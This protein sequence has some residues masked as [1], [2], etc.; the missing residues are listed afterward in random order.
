MKNFKLNKRNAGVASAASKACAWILSIM[1]VVTGLAPSF[2]NNAKAGNGSATK[3]AKVEAK[4]KTPSKAEV[5][6]KDKTTSK[7]KAP[8]KPVASKKDVSSSSKKQKSSKDNDDK[9]GKKKKFKNKR[10]KTFKL[11]ESGNV[12]AEIVFE[13]LRIKVSFGHDDRNIDRKKWG[14]MV[15]ALGGSYNENNSERI[16]WSNA[17]GFDKLSLDYYGVYLPKDSSYF[18]YGFKKDIEKDSWSKKIVVDNVE[19]MSHMFEAS[20]VPSMNLSNWKLNS[21]LLGDSN[22]MQN[23]LTGCSNLEWLKTPVGLKTSISGANNNFKIVKL[24]KGSAAVVESENKNLNNDYEINSAGDKDA[25]YHIYRKDTH[26]GVTFDKNSGDSDSFRNHE[27]VKKGK[28]FNELSGE[29]PSEVPKKEGYIFTGW[30]YNRADKA[31]T[32]DRSKNI[33]DDITLYAVYK[34]IKEEIPLNDSGNV[35]V[36]LKIEV[37]GKITL[38]VKAKNLSGDM[39]ID[40]SK[41]DDMARK[42]GVYYANNSSGFMSWGES[43]I[44]NIHF[45][46]NGIDLPTDSSYLFCRLRGEIK[47]CEKVNTS[48][49]T[50]M[51]SMFQGIDSADPDVSRWNTSNVTNMASMFDG[52]KN[53]NPDVSNWD[54]SKVTNMQAMFQ[55]GSANPDVSKW[56]VSK[57]TNMQAMFRKTEIREVDLSKWKLNAKLLGNPDNADAMFLGCKNLSFLK[58]PVGLK[59][60][61][62]YLGRST[63]KIVKLKKGSVAVVEQEHKELNN[64]GYMINSS[65]DKDA[66]YYLYNRYYYFGVTFDKNDGDDESWMNYEIAS[67]GHSIKESKGVLPEEKPGKQGY[68]FKGWDKYAGAT[69]SGNFT[70]DTKVDSDITVYAIYEPKAPAK[71]KF[72]A[73]GGELGAIPAEINTF[74]GD[75]LGDKFPVEHPAKNG[76]E[77]VGWSKRAEDSNTGKIT[78]GAEFN[79]DTVIDAATVEVYAVWKAKHKLTVSFDGNGGELGSIPTSKDVY[80]G[81]TLGS[82]FPAYDPKNVANMDPKKPGHTFIGWG[83]DKTSTMPE[84]TKDTVFTKSEM[85]YAVWK[86]GASDTIAVKF[87][88]N[89]GSYKSGKMPSE[90][91]ERGTAL[92]ARFPTEIPEKPGKA[93]LG[94]A[95][96]ASATEPDITPETIFNEGADVY[97]V[98]KDAGSV[99]KVEFDMQGGKPEIAPIYAEAGKKLGDRFPKTTPRKKGYEFVGY[100]RSKA[101]ADTGEITYVNKVDKDTNIT[102]DTLAYAAFKE[103]KMVTIT[104]AANGGNGNMDAAQVDKG[105]NYKLPECKFTAP[106][107]KEFDK[108]SVA[109]GSAQAADQNP[110]DEIVASDNVTVTAKWKAKPIPKVNITF[111]NDGGTG[112][113]NAAEIEKGK[114]YTLPVC[115][116]VPPAGKEFDKWSVTVGS[117]PAVDKKPGESVTASDNVAVKAMWKTKTVPVMA[118]VTLHAEGVAGYPQ[119]I[120]VKRGE[121]LGDKLPAKIEKA[122]Y[123]F[124]GYSKENNGDINFFSDTAVKE[125]MNVYAVYKSNA[126]VVKKV[127]NIRLTAGSLRMQLGDLTDVFAI[128]APNDATDKRVKFTLDREDIIKI[129]SADDSAARVEAI[130]EGRV[131]VKAE[132][133]DG[134]GVT[135]EVTIEV[136]RKPVKKVQVKLNAEGVSGYPKTIETEEGTSLDANLPMDLKKDGYIFRGWSYE[137]NGEVNFTKHTQVSKNV[138]VHA[139]F[140]K[141]E[142]SALFIAEGATG[143]P[144]SVTVERGKK[145]GDKLPANPVRAGYDFEGW[146]TESSFGAL[147]LT[148][149]TVIDKDEIVYAVFKKQGAIVKQVSSITLGVTKSNIKAGDEADVIASIL[150][151]DADDKRLSWESSAPDKLKIEQTGDNFIRIKAEEEGT[152]TITAKAKDGSNVEANI[153]IKVLSKISAPISNKVKVMI[154]ADGVADYPKL[155]EI[156]KN[157]T[158][159]GKLPTDINKPGY[160]FKGFTKTMGNP[161]DFDDNEVIKE[162]TRLYAVFEQTAAPTKKVTG[163]EL[164]KSKSKVAVGDTVDILPSIT[165]EDADN[166]A[167]DYTVDNKDKALIYKNPDGTLRLY[168]ML[169]GKVTVTAKATDG[170]NVTKSIEIEIIEADKEQVAVTLN[171]EGINGYPKQLTVDKGEALGNALPNVL[172]KADYDFRGWSTT[173]NGIIDVNRLTPMTSSISIYAVFTKKQVNVRMLAEGVNGYPKNVSLDIHSTL[174]SELP[175]SLNKEGYT[176]KGWSKDSFTGAV[177]VTAATKIDESMTIYAVFERQKPVTQKVESIKIEDLSSE[178]KVI[179]KEFN[180]F[181]NILPESADDKTLEWSASDPAVKIVQKQNNLVSVTANAPGNYSI[182]AKAK[183]GSNVT[184]TFAFT[185]EVAAPDVRNV[186]LLATDVAG[187]PKDIKV[188]KG[189]NLVGRLPMDL[190]K[191]GYTFLGW[192][193]TQGAA[194]ADFDASLP[195]TDDLTLYAVFKKNVAPPAPG[196]TRVTLDGNGGVLAGGAQANIDIESGDTIKTQL[197][198][199]VANKIFTKPGYKFIGFSRSKFAT[200]ADYNLESPVYTDMTLYAVY[201]E[202]PVFTDVTIKYDIFDME[203]VVIENV[204]EGKPIGSKLDGH[205]KQRDGF[206]FMGFAKTQ[207]AIKP[208]FFRKSIVTNGL[209]L[210]PV[211]KEIGTVDKVKV[212]F[213]L[214]DGTDA[215]LQ[216]K[217]VIRYESLGDKMPTK[218][219]V[220]ERDGYL[221]TGWAK[222]KAAKYPDFF[223]GTTVKG[224]MTVY[225]IWKSLYDEKLG[226]AVLKVAAKAKGYELTIEPPKAN[227]HTGF[228]IFRSEKKDFKPSKD[229]KIATVDRNTLKYQDDK[230]DNAKAYY[231]AVRPIDEDGS[232]NGTKVTFIGK[233]SDKVLAAPLP[234]DK[235]VTATVAGKGA[236]SLEFNKTIAAAKYKVTVTAPYDKKFKTIERFVEAGK[237]AIAGGNKVKANL[238]GL[239]MGKFLA[240]KLEALEADNNKLVE[241]GNSFAFMLGAVDKLSAKVNKKKRVLNIKFKAMKGVNGYEAKIVIGGKVKTIKLKKGKKKLNKFMVGSI[242]LPKKK[243]NYTFTIRA[244]KKIGKLKYYG[245]TITKVVK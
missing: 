130:G 39:Q 84:V 28:A 30:A 225:A 232:Y 155:I 135:G 199:A 131:K 82:D 239:P 191:D 32:F 2:A 22:K 141:D 208:D 230:A 11:N 215:S 147:N 150:P 211:Y 23:M 156:D 226:Q 91:F 163:I 139:V 140:K 7:V 190:E 124:L 212:A 154:S 242:K 182:T 216:S 83:Y 205:V 43:A 164:S 90:T 123:D 244:F 29:V 160:K 241:Y 209:V 105:S 53:A 206:R 54:V 188:T 171:A 222:S 224:D 194:E 196:K 72:N 172:D 88:A 20:S 149:D 214:N 238:T 74:I 228:D 145:I 170:S 203:N 50:N 218:D 118:K 62:I 229:N 243:G 25:A 173:P 33:D 19:N 55:Q 195:V 115:T 179:N 31:P 59:T 40:R 61:V 237:L 78:P 129:V 48:K 231:Y 107:G 157:T 79:K 187:Y 63:F 111:D 108:W 76:Y 52:T 245:Q 95:N 234:K 64:I 144:K 128:V 16:D 98:W 93:F 127:E 12:Y 17:S 133:L 75:S 15:K 219:S 27:I 134:S 87:D 85:L 18:F 80:V 106:A 68:R 132:A 99:Y 57:V 9:N 8:N 77:F 221:F 101:E 69:G 110:G 121:T 162:D 168:A 38:E 5:A 148:K 125:D 151:A 217:E 10:Y 36:L 46:V 213:K 21:T 100:T 34:N 126:P 207:D 58:T 56:D 65:G 146:S 236:V 44:N 227:L 177:N 185:V 96:S 153:E 169:K 67:R 193:K 161:A 41:W 200:A 4:A 175:A 167:L 180:L 45:E 49:V 166:K 94:Y 142:V 201:E 97:A 198:S 89:G 73:M 202:A 102:K 223:R 181:A 66:V 116:F 137:K 47:G 143:F 122:G 104:F 103:K 159:H 37:N 152:Y 186:K 109:I 60:Y 119:V 51:R 117:A 42:L 174:G 176:F 189:E 71:L 114:D 136:V 233:L 3:T 92:G 26:V 197:E 204:A 6:T 86:K 184:D 178:S 70:E 138:E 220:P 13:E 165:P 24:K 158:L 35:Y 120:E 81:E 183:D 113:M 1:L 192:S 112:S 240:F 235:G 210:Y 14:E